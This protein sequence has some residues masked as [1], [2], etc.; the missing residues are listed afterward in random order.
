[1]AYNPFDLFRRN[2]KIIFAGLTIVIM[3]MF[4]FSFGRGDFFDWL[5]RW[6]GQKKSR[7]EVL[8]VID[9]DKFRESESSQIRNRRRLANQYMSAAARKALEELQGTAKERSDKVSPENRPVVQEA[10]QSIGMLGFLNQI[11]VQSR[12]MFF[13]QIVKGMQSGIEKLEKLLAK[14]GVSQDDLD[15]ANSV[16][17]LLTL[18]LHMMR[19]GN[20][21]Y[22]YNQPNKSA[23]DAIDYTLWLK[24]ADQLKIHFR[25]EDVDGLVEQEFLRLKSDAR[26]KILNEMVAEGRQN[27][28]TKD[29]ILEAIGDEFRV[30]LAQV[31]VMGLP[32]VRSSNPADVGHAPFDYYEFYRTETSPVQYSVIT[33]PVENYVSKVEGQPTETELREI[34]NKAKNTE[35]DPGEPKIGIKK[36]RELKLGYVEITGKEPFY[37]AAATDALVKGEVAA[38]MAGLFTVPFGSGA[39]AN[40]LS[41]G[42]LK[43]E[44][45]ALQGAY[46]YYRYVHGAN[47]SA[48]WFTT[49]SSARSLS[50]PLDTTYANAQVAAAT[51]G[52]AAGPLGTAANRFTVSNATIANAD[53]AERRQRLFAGLA[54]IAPPALS[55]PAVLVQHM[56]NFATT[57]SGLPKALPLAA[58]KGKLVTEVREGLRFGLAQ[59]DVQKFQDEIA[60]IHKDFEKDDD[61]EKGGREAAAYIAKFANPAS[62][63]IDRDGKPQLGRGL[64]LGGSVGFADVHSI[65]D[66]PGLAAIKNRLQ[67]Q[68]GGQRTPFGRRFFFEEDFRTG[69]PRIA[70][71]LYSPVPYPEVGTQRAAPLPNENDSQYLVWRSAEQPSEAAKDF[72]KA[73]PKVVEIWKRQKAREL[74]KKAAE[75]L[76]AKAGTLGKDPY[77]LDGKLKDLIV[78]YRSAYPK[79][80]PEYDRAKT[81]EIANVARI[82]I[83]ERREQ[84]GMA[85]V[86]T[87][88]TVENLRS[89]TDIAYPTPK[90]AEQLVDHRT[91][92]IATSFVM[93]DKPESNYYVAVLINRV[94]SLESSFLRR[95]YSPEADPARSNQ[96]AEDLAG[97]FDQEARKQARE[98]AIELLK[99]EFNYEKETENKEKLSGT[100]D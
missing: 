48:R 16:R 49:E 7:G 36:G 11:P 3:V 41:A 56:G 25:T 2:Q 65:G 20:E 45:P 94:V 60:K 100:G 64:I 86:G 54:M 9:G 42:M 78:Q 96:I 6:L 93:V 1:M 17:K 97:L 68:H 84:T 61:K 80:S 53:I 55:G 13:Q 29:A 90:M 43:V 19:S 51:V 40:A 71:G 98:E 73:R 81:F 66:D 70:T 35:A 15:A 95:V 8:A 88:Y 10:Q 27:G 31:A 58:V 47:L 4:I 12:E 63:W 83:S 79:F 67:R 30:R 82:N 39:I 72:D 14:P 37:A 28:V 85:L 77:V 21:H 75:E 22:F 50:T 46:D 91:K 26:E 87:P 52:L 99:A 5:P 76:A 33:V 18:S 62:N 89:S 23:K 92:D 59:S 69:Q 38:K 24:K 57:N 44:D 32:E 34:F 74:A